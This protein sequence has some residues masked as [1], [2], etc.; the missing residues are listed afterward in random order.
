[1]ALSDEARE[2]RIEEAA[3]SIDEA[4]MAGFG[5]VGADDT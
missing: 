5:A 2:A 1:M 3:V 4:I